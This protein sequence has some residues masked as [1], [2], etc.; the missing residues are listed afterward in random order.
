MPVPYWR[1]KQKL[2]ELTRQSIK[3]E[4]LI[5][6]VDME[7]AGASLPW[8]PAKVYYF[9]FHH[10]CT[11]D[12][13][14]NPTKGRPNDN[15]RALVNRLAGW[16]KTSELVFSDHLFNQTFTIEDVLGRIKPQ[17]TQLRA[18]TNDQTL[19][20][21]VMKNTA[22]HM[23]DEYKTTHKVTRK[24]VDQE[25]FKQ[26]KAHNPTSIFHYP[27]A[28]RRRTNY[29]DIAFIDGASDEDIASY[30]DAYLEFGWSLDEALVRLT[31]KLV[32]ARS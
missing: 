26:F 11:I 23:M 2:I 21:M 28:M 4:A 1:D 17:A 31:D 18:G 25:K 12:Y 16:L 27:L 10:F 8:I 14:I 32:A 13:L 20:E 5:R 30:F 6:S 3:A 15:H 29:K 24:Q 7:Y 19:F 22:R 9:L